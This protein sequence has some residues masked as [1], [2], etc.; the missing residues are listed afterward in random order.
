MFTSLRDND[1]TNNKL[2]LSKITQGFEYCGPDRKHRNR[3]MLR[4]L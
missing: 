1:D 2:Y 4:Y 3:Q